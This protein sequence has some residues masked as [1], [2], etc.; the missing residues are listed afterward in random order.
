MN[1]LKR[2]SA[3]DVSYFPTGKTFDANQLKDKFDIILLWENNSYGMPEEIKNIDNLGL[4]IICK[5]SDPG[6]AK[7]SIPFHKKWNIDHYFHFIDRDYFYELYPKNFK[8]S[9]IMFGVE[10]CLYEKI[11]PFKERIKEK[12]LNSGNVGNSKFLSQLISKIRTP[13]WNAWSQYKLRRMCVNLPYVDY[14]STLKHEFINDNYP[15]LLQK[16]RAAIAASTYN[17]SAKF[18]EIPSA[19]CLTFMEIT[20]KNKGNN[21]GF[22]DNE[23]AIFINEKNYQEKFKDYL[24]DMDNPKWERIAN[25]GRKFA[26]ENFNNDKAVDSLVSL[27]ENLV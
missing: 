16:Y 17:P 25:N 6:Q 7:T 8:F 4:P 11:I 20:Q 5:A 18:W 15:K 14:T 1:A 13:R 22:V 26:L 23:T 21:L 9:T 24:S 3:L 27:I 10:P 12:I 2:N 19:G